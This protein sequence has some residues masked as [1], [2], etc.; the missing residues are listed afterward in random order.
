MW[1]RHLKISGVLGWYHEPVSHKDTHM[2]FRTH[3]LGRNTGSRI[4]AHPPVAAFVALVTVLAVVAAGDAQADKIDQYVVTQ[5]IR[6]HIPALSLAVVKNGRPVKQKGYGQANLE[7]AV[8]ASTAT[9]YQIGSISK[10]FIAA[11]VLLLSDA[12]KLGLA[13]PVRKYLPDAPE[14]WQPITIRHLLTHTSG[15][16]REAPGSVLEAQSDVETVRSAYS[17]PLPFAPG[18]KWQYSNLGYSVLA[19]IITTAAQMPWPEYVRNRI[20]EPLAMTATRTTTAEEL[21]PLRASGYQWMDNNSYHNAP[22]VHG[23]RPSGA[24]LSNVLDLS[25]WDAALY[26]ASFL[27]Q[28]Q[29]ELMWT[30]VKLNDGSEKPYGFGWEL[31]KLGNHRQTK[32]A[33]TMLGFRSQILRFPDDGLTIVVL[34][35]ATQATPEKIASGVAAFY[36][37]DLKPPQPK[38]SIANVSADVLDRYVGRYQFPGRELTLTRRENNLALSM[39]MA[40]PALGTDVAALLRGVSMPLAVLTPEN[41]TRFFDEDDPNSSYVFA[42]GTDGNVQLSLENA[43]GKVLQSGLKIA[44]EH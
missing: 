37:S 21:V 23:V 24:F 36:I 39:P 16:Q 4:Q 32:H 35:N 3:L 29:R 33:G 43:Q 10:Q 38:R 25:K 42:V 26:S 2:H 44:R 40:M 6:Q 41:E 28:Q 20:F 34:T 14:A 27:S 13:D 7:L 5:M 30:P 19:E 11:A 22:V 17:L 12:G 9:V 15:L 1:L 8:R 18:E 31:A